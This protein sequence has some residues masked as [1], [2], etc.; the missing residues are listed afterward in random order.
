ML[1]SQYLER[2]KKYYWRVVGEIAAAHILEK[3]NDQLSSMLNVA[4]EDCDL[5]VPSEIDES[6]AH[7]QNQDIYFD[8]FDDE[9]ILARI[10]E[11]GLKAEY[12]TQVFH[13][14]RQDVEELFTQLIKDLE[15]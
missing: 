7:S 9:Q 11:H 4:V 14:I 13:A 12:E 10:R 5:L 2:S 6:F 8:I 3:D 15:L 1:K